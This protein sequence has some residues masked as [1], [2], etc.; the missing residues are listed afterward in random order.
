[1]QKQESSKEI[2]WTDSKNVL[3]E[4][5]YVLHVSGVISHGIIDIRRISLMHPLGIE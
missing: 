5:V 4:L 3:I 1:M 2:F